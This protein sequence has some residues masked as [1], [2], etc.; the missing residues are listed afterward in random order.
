ML[1]QDFIEKL[2]H[3][4]SSHAHIANRY[5]ILLSH[6]LTAAS[7]RGQRPSVRHGDAGE[8]ASAGSPGHHAGLAT[9][10]QHFVH[11]TGHVDAQQSDA[12]HLN[13][14]D[15]NDGLV[16]WPDCATDNDL[17]F[18]DGSLDFLPFPGPSL[19]DLARA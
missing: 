2:Q 6:L 18:L 10:G 11:E 16:P 5:A 7:V 8:T 9:Q 1:V 19:D 3:A 13:G 17:F 4:A 15:T 14:L 12:R